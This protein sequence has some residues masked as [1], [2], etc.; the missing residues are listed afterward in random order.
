MLNSTCMSSDFNVCFSVCITLQYLELKGKCQKQNFIAGKY[1][2]RFKLQFVINIF[3]LFSYT[4]S[5][6]DLI[7][8]H[9]FCPVLGCKNWPCHQTFT[10]YQIG[11]CKLLTLCQKTTNIFLFKKQLS[12]L[13][14]NSWH[15]LMQE[16]HVSMHKTYVYTNQTMLY[17]HTHFLE[18][19]ETFLCP[20]SV[21]HLQQ[22]SLDWLNY[23]V[24]S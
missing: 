24:Y 10:W 16:N 7:S 12:Q 23:L 21:F 4:M 17:L 22:S 11:W 14:N 3:M 15:S 13:K 9:V 5:I 1:Q 20:H 6:F 19:T 2:L 8:V 18:Y